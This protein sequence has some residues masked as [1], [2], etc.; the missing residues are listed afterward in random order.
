[1]NE[2]KG[3]KLVSD[4]KFGMIKIEAVGR[5]SVVKELRG[6]YTRRSEAMKAIDKLEALKNNGKKQPSK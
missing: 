6:E 4:G 5:G 3:Y 1:M 2:Y